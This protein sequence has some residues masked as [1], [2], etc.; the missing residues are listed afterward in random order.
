MGLPL[1]KFTWLISELY[2]TEGNLRE[3]RK[4]RSKNK[5]KNIRKSKKVKKK[6]EKLI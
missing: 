5:G 1:G 3:K 2:V 4:K 6:G